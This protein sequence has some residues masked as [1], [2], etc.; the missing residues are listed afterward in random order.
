M[1]KF[2]DFEL[3]KIVPDLDQTHVSTTVKVRAMEK[4]MNICEQPDQT[5]QVGSVKILEQSYGC[6]QK[7]FWVASS[8][9]V[10]AEKRISRGVTREERC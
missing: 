6:S 7:R 10:N 3:S 8:S 9:A 4:L 5:E 1:A 2:A